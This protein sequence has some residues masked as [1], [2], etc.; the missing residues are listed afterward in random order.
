MS[1]IRSVKSTRTTLQFTTP[2]PSAFRIGNLIFA[3]A[4]S[5][6]ALCAA[7]HAA[8]AGSLDGGTNSGS[9]SAAYGPSARADGAGS[10]AVGGEAGAMAGDATAIGAGVVATGVNSTAVGNQVQVDA[11]GG[12][13]IA[14]NYGTRVAVDSA[15]VNGIAIGTNS[16]VRNAPSAIAIGRATSTTAE[17]G[18][19]IGGAASATAANSVAL[20][21]GAKTTSDL[22]AAGYN[23]GSGELS[24]VASVANGE[25]S[26][27][28]T[29]AERRM[30]NVAAGSAPT[31]AVNV[32]QLKSADAKINEIGGSTAA[33]LGGGSAYD[34]TT[35]SISAP[36]YTILK[37]DGTATTVNSVGDALA[38]V[39]ATA[40]YFRADGN[41]DGTD[42]ATVAAGMH[43]VAMGANASAQAENS[44]AIGA[45]SVADRAN[46]LSV[47]SAGSERQ[48]TNVAAGTQDTDAVN[49][50]QM[51]EYGTGVLQQAN[52]YTDQRTGNA[53]QQANAYTDKQVAG[54]RRDANAGSASAM[55]MAG[56]P[57]AVLPGKG[58]VALAAST[59]AGESALALG[60]STLSGTGKWVYKA[61]LTTNTRGNVGAAVGAG[62]HW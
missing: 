46:T 16:A 3:R 17:N 43:A 24:G 59:Y 5:A 10:L 9:L 27:G 48:V 22:A 8:L 56:L 23:P 57:Q 53:L 15:S 42:A 34:A 26:L 20:G 29:G 41:G 39:S 32:S 12:I 6:I 62:F 21:A 38:A 13:G 40:G 36:A 52:A 54:V 45:N 30:T 18:V 19:A 37:S 25:V 47:G 14:G 2:I 4:V 49:L 60:V 35:G 50:V 58:M 31:D 28:S 51:K 44:V 61:N 33:A 55:A 1:N 7:S 11:E